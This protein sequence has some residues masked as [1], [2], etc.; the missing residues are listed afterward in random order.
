MLS[1]K[2]AFLLLIAVAVVFEIV[3]DVLLKRWAIANR[4]PILAVG[5]FLYFVGT[6][7]WAFSLRYEHLSRAIVV[8]TVVNLVVITF[9]GVLLFQEKLTLWNKIGIGLGTVS[10]L[11]L[12]L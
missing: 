11:L 6:V 8:F 5:L 4:W 3:A 7:F 12:E 10:V 2:Q 1:P 9:V